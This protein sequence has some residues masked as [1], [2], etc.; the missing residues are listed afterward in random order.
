M[1]ITV[2]IHA[3]LEKKICFPIPAPACVLLSYT[4]FLGAS[5]VRSEAPQVQ[6]ASLWSWW[7]RLTE[8][9]EHRA[10]LPGDLARTRRC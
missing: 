2:L 7:G 6:E 4:H 9:E 5:R 10:G 8:Q 1:I 3:K